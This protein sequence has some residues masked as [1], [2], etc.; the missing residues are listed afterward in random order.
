MN[1]Q[2]AQR[3]RI[4]YALRPKVSILNQAPALPVRPESSVPGPAG[5]PGAPAP[6]PPAGKPPC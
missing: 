2:T 4:Y 1:A 3:R 6:T 5:G